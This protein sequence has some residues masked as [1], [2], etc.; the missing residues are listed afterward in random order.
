MNMGE[1]HAKRQR[2]ALRRTALAGKVAP[3]VARILAHAFPLAPRTRISPIFNAAA[4][5]VN[6]LRRAVTNVQCRS[7]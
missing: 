1:K 7:R 6:H 3:V 4:H 5:A 2:H